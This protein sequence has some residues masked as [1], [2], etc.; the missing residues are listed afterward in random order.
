EPTSSTRTPSSA[1]GSAFRAAGLSS[2]A[3]T[4]M[5]FD[6]R[7]GGPSAVDALRTHGTNGHT[8]WNDGQKRPFRGTARASLGRMA[9]RGRRREQE[10]LDRLIA[11]V[12]EGRSAALVLRGEPGIG[13][14]ALLD[15]T[16]ERATGAR[17]LWVRGV[18]PE[19]ELAYAGLHQLC[20]PLG[21]LLDM[22][23]DP[24]REALRVALGQSSNTSPP[25][26]FLVGLGV[27][28][29]LSEA[30]GRS[31]VLCVVDDADWLDRESLQALAFVARRLGAEAV[32][33]LFAVR[34]PVRELAGLTELELRGLADG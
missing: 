17:V 4:A 13:K 23:P 30:A 18:E 9:L 10:A 8:V 12:R 31:P 21:D 16:V 3:G 5:R 25:E 26:P 2:C 34:A 28:G 27:L 11:G 6:A 29:L 24:Q 32:A 15:S 14:T 19:M 33:I 7:P 20:A 1:P 22:L